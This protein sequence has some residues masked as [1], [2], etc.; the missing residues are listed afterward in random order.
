[1]K[2]VLITIITVLAV[3]SVIGMVVA[4]PEISIEKGK[5]LFNDPKLGTNSKTCGT[6][7]MDG[8]GLER[9]GANADLVRVINGCIV[10]PLRGKALEDTSAEMQSLVL[11]IKSLA[12][13]QSGVKKPS[14]GC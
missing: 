4:A 10:G 2:G 8:K 13:K 12:G 11:Y 1:M 3:F 5:A 14:V 7:H 9:S 6:C